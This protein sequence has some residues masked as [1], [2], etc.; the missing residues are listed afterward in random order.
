M[1]WLIVG[2]NPSLAVFFSFFFSSVSCPAKAKYFMDKCGGWNTSFTRWT[3]IAYPTSPFASAAQYISLGHCD[4]LADNVEH[5]ALVKC[6]LKNK[7]L[8]V[9]PVDLAANP[10]LFFVTPKVLKWKLKWQ[11]KQIVKWKKWQVH[12][13]KNKTQ[14]TVLNDVTANPLSVCFFVAGSCDIINVLLIS[15]QLYQNCSDLL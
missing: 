15:W 10:H 2:L 3:L 11:K 4:F 12:R 13:Q 7:S 14:F 5:A 1:D 9:L 6:V 8:M